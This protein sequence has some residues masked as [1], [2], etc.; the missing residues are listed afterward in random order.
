MQGYLKSISSCVRFGTK[1]DFTGKFNSSLQDIFV[2]DI[3]L[4][5]VY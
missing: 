3:L 1:G 4:T 5:F 2:I